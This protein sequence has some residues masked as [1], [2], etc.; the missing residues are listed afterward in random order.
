[1]NKWT[2]F[3]DSEV[4]G[5][6]DEFIAKLDKAR[7]LAGIPFIITSGF[8]S[9]EA[10]QSIAGSVEDSSHLSGLAVDLRVSESPARFTIV[11]ALI[12]VGFTRIGIYD[13][14]VHVDADPTKPQNV[15]WVGVSH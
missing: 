8:R 14:H 5:L 2:Y 6:K 1:M 4:G 3:N 7:G 9:L 15:I 12:E 11:K 10:N 13:K